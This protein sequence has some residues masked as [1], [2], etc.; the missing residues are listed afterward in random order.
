MCFRRLS[1]CVYS[2]ISAHASALDKDMALPASG[3]R[4]DFLISGGDCKQG[5]VGGGGPDG[6]HLAAGFLP[7][8]DSGSERDA[9]RKPP[10]RRQPFPP[11][12]PRQRLE[13]PEPP[14]VTRP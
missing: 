6:R 5:C 12:N 7:R 13:G 8:H 10:P 2:V 3:R 1:P 11:W 4:E 9:E 14:P